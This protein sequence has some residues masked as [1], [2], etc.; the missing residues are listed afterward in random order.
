MGIQVD[1]LTQDKTQLQ[2]YIN[3]QFDGKYISDFGLVVV[4]DGDRLSFD[5]SAEFEDEV[6]S[7]N[8][9][10]GQYYWGTN[11]KSLKREFTLAT[12]G[13]TEAQVN[14]FKQHFKPGKYGNFI[15]DKISILAVINNSL[16]SQDIQVL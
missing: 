8:G 6:S 3:F 16:A 9:V 5:G 13:M 15:E 11:F 7:V 1:L 10:N 14:A 4:T 12:D 2:D